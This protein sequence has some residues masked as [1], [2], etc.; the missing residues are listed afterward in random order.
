[1]TPKHSADR[2]VR[3][4]ARSGEAQLSLGESPTTGYLWRLTDL[5][6]EVEVL[7]TEFHAA[8]TKQLGASGERRFHLRAQ[9]PGSYRFVARL[10]RGEDPPDEEVTVKFEVSAT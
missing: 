4:T 3:L 6:P 9:A 7:N 2:E 8:P 10:A 5:P 1:M